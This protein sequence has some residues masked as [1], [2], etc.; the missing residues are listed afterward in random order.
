MLAA[1]SG[2]PMCGA[3][4]GVA[5]PVHEDGEPDLEEQKSLERSQLTASLAVA[6]A[7][8]REA[9]RGSLMMRLAEP[10]QATAPPSEWDAER[11][12]AG[13]SPLDESQPESDEESLS[14]SDLEERLLNAT[15]YYCV[16]PSA[17]AEQLCKL[18]SRFLADR[19]WEPWP[20]EDWFESS[21]TGEMLSRP[22]HAQSV[23][24]CN[25]G[26]YCLISVDIGA[27]EWAYDRL[28]L[29]DLAPDLCPPSFKIKAGALVG[30][31]AAEFDASSE[32][33]MWFLKENGRN[34]GQ[35][36]DVVRTAAEA[37]VLAAEREVDTPGREFVLQP[38]VHRALLYDGKYKFHVRVYALMVVSPMLRYP[39]CFGYSAAFMHVNP[40]PWSPTQLEKAVQSVHGRS[41]RPKSGW[42]SPKEFRNWEHYDIVEPR[43][44]STTA[45]LLDRIEQKLGP[46]SGTNRTYVPL[47]SCPSHPHTVSMLFLKHELD[48]SVTT[49]THCLVY[50]GRS[51]S[52]D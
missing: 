14:S 9:R 3:S 30:A 1:T 44:M 24:F 12:L 31:L 37:L 2:E 26:S 19:G 52:L 32:S 38:H 41:D 28:M 35:G 40:L 18:M 4:A 22:A 36:I 20:Y 34:A 46:Q 42:D 17:P 6:A 45:T 21:E 7:A 47:S 15:T 10:D 49:G 23:D 8:A 51:R 48:L 50:A 25:C 11:E 27:A 13:A 33:P 39:R 43:L 5:A 16:V 29:S